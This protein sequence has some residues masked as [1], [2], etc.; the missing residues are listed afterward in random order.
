MIPVVD[1]A[2]TPDQTGYFGPESVTWRVLTSPAAALM[3]AQ[4]TN[5]LEVPHID[6]QNV[7]VD[8]DPLFPTNRKRQRGQA[9]DARK[10]GHFHDRLRRTLSVPLPIVFG[11]RQ[12]AEACAARLFNYHRPMAGVGADGVEPYSAVA[13]ESMLF[14]A[15]TISHAALIAYERFDLVDGARP[16]R[17]SE[18]DRDRYFAEMAQLAV[19]MG[20]PTA[21]IPRSSKDIGA[22]YAS[23]DSKFTSRPGFRR[24]QLRTALALLRPDGLGDIR[25]TI[26][27]IALIGSA[28]VAYT[29]LPKPSR[30]LHGLP[31]ITDP[32]LTAAY[33]A[34]LPAFALLRIDAVR[35]AAVTGYL[36]P[37][38]AAVLTEARREIAVADVRTRGSSRYLQSRRPQSP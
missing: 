30:R 15:V 2:T 14:A 10:G 4:I 17:L 34:S 23:L 7:L 9:P 36:G 6:F 38:D 12:S 29:A 25:A 8:H 28:A 27:D 3:I 26:T 18:T 20:V 13:P 31:P 22:Y 5:L 32:L 21:S 11:D 16:A 19:L 33:Y 35:R 1:P 37:A 24:A